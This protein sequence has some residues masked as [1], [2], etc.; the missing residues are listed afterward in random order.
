MRNPTYKMLVA[1]RRRAWEFDKGSWVLGST[2]YIDMPKTRAD[3]EIRSWRKL[4]LYEE[5]ELKNSGS[6]LRLQVAI[7][8]DPHAMRSVA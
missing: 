5:F 1:M 4:C 8:P 3:V 2:S 7:P 6:R